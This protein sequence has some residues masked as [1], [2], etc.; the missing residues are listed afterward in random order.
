[1]TLDLL[2]GFWQIQMGSGSQKKTAF[3]TPQGLYEFLVMPFGLT[4]TPAVF[5]T[6]I[7][8]VI[9]GLSSLDGKGFVTT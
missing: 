7:K 9:S 4:N 2:S 1:M 3:T 8:R 6:L 5:Q